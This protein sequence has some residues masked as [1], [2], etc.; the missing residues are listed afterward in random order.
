MAMFILLS[1]YADTEEV[2]GPSASE[3][4]AYLEPIE[5]QGGIWILGVEVLDDPAHAAHHAY[6]STFPQMDSANPAFPP[7]LSAD[8]L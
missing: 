7:A 3:P 4:D 5:R 1:S 6:L 8:P 2:R